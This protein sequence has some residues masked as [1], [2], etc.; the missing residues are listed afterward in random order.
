MHRA[1]QHRIILVDVCARSRDRVARRNR[2]EL[3]AVAA[4]DIQPPAATVDHH[5]E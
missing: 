5:A 1:A 3:G 2:V 4:L